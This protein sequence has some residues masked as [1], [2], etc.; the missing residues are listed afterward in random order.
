MFKLLSN[1]VNRHG[2]CA[3]L[4]SYDGMFTGHAQN[5]KPACCW[6]NH[7]EEEK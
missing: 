1:V 4:L 7:Q 5:E 2:G 6:D 3:L